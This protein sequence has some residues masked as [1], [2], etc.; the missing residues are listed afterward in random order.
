MNFGLD[1]PTSFNFSSN[2]SHTLGTEKKSVGLASFKVST[3]LPYKASGLAKYIVA[4]ARIGNNRSQ[5]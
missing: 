4:L 3:R 1:A 5:H 2:F